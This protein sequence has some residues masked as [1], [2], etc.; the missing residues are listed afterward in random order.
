LPNTFGDGVHAVTAVDQDG[1][2]DA[3]VVDIRPEQQV[4]TIVEEKV[5]T[6]EVAKEVM[7]QGL[8]LWVT[9]LY[10]IAM[11]V[12]LGMMYFSRRVKNEDGSPSRAKTAGIVMSVLVMVLASVLYVYASISFGIIKGVVLQ[13]INWQA[14]LSSMSKV[15]PI[16]QKYLSVSGIV[17]DPHN[18][19][20]VEN[21]SI[22]AEGTVVKTQADGG[23]A[24][25]SVIEGQGVE[26]NYETLN[27]PLRYKVKEGRQEIIFDLALYN[28]AIALMDYE[29]HNKIDSIYFEILSSKT[30]EKL[31]LDGF[32]KS[33]QK[34]FN[35]LNDAMP[36]LIVLDFKLWKDFVSLEFG[37]KHELVAEMLLGNGQ[38]GQATYYFA[39]E[40]GNWKLIK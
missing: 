24:I 21:L 23:F 39:F 27:R 7:P 9:L 29:A 36:E 17:S 35:K 20:G 14:A 11:F 15:A 32:S 38:G 6:K 8:F 26:I 4:K 1:N 5:I 34:N 33:Y 18:R 16:E 12:A 10:L 2:K 28:E 40:S 31:T 13:N 25:G 37:T 30:Q 19:Q 3:V 22:S